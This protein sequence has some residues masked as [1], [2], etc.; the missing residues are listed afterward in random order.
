MST[1]QDIVDS[2]EPI[3][4]RVIAMQTATDGGLPATRDDLEVII[5]LVHAVE[6]IARALDH[7]TVVSSAPG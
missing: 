1:K 3:R 5:D 4:R 6:S 2:L 7:D